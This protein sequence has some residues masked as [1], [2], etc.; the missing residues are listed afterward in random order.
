MKYFFK[1]LVMMSLLGIV[2]VFVDVLNSGN[3]TAKKMD[4]KMQKEIKQEKLD[5]IEEEIEEL[6]E[7]K[8]TQEIWLQEG[9]LLEEQAALEEELHPEEYYKQ[10][11][12]IEIDT[13]DAA[14]SDMK[15]ALDT[16]NV[17]KEVVAETQ[18]RVE[19]YGGIL[20]EYRKVY[21]S[22]EYSSLEEL[23]KQEH[24]KISKLHSYFEEKYN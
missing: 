19:K 20:E 5:H 17:P 9:E 22:G 18:E 16:N 2:L 13:I 15:I 11:I 3:V 12:K 14:V 8:T 6:Q 10:Q 7:Q 23:F 1:T 21:E 24:E 4:I